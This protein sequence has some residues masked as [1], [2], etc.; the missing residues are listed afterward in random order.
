MS[1]DTKNTSAVR[2]AAFA[3][4]GAGVIHGTA[5]GLHADHAAL[6]RVFL[7][8]T[9]AQVGWGVIALVSTHRMLALSGLA[10]NAVAVIGWALTRTV[11]ISFIDGLQIVEKPQSADTICALLGAAAVLAVLWSMV[12]A[13]KSVSSLATMNAAYIT[14]GATLFAMFAVT[15]HAHSHVTIDDSTVNGG[16]TV[17]AK[18]VIISPTDSSSA[19]TTTVAGSTKSAS[20]AVVVTTTTVKKTKSTV[21][22]TTTVHA[23][24]QTSDQLLAAASGWPRSWDPARGEDFSGINGATAD[25]KARA[26]ALLANNARDLAKYANVSAAT[27][28]G[29][30][31]I[32][33]ASTGFEHMMNYSLLNDGRVLDTNAPE[34]LV[35]QVNG[36]SRTLVSAMYIAN[37]GTAINDSTLVNYAGGLMQW[38]VHSNLCWTSQNGV[39][40]VVGVTDANGNCPAGSIHQTGGAPMVHV[41]IGANPCGPFA[42][43]EGNGAGVA[44]LPDNQRVDKCNAQH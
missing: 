16:L 30:I 17:D 35:Y 44:D 32:G 5:V 41:W 29:Y 39:P 42:A 28:A 13:G 43:L 14:V 26:V 24:I 3:S 15:G 33:D 19:P 10:I 20:A 27:A 25:Q 4:I 1:G 6:S 22:P 40:K 18:G 23:H 21:A 31:S 9:I 8:L 38:H 7:L 2:W 36:T 11:G 37:P 34:S 12:S